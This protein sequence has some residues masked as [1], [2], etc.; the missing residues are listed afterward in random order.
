MRQLRGPRIQTVKLVRSVYTLYHMPQAF[1]LSFLR[2]SSGNPTLR[3]QLTAVKYKPT[4]YIPISDMKQVLHFL[5]C[6]VVRANHFGFAGHLAAEWAHVH[7]RRVF[8]PR[9]LGFRHQHFSK[10]VSARSIRSILVHRTFPSRPS[11]DSCRQNREVFVFPL[12]DGATWGSWTGQG[13]DMGKPRPNRVCTV[14]AVN[15]R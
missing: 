10:R 8:E 4:A 3:V 6:V 5:Q 12:A 14:R 11:W 7:M 13:S 9:K 2:W 15:E 1:G